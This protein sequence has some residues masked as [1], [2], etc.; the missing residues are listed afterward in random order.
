[1][2]TAIALDA[3]SARVAWPA[4]ATVGHEPELARVQCEA[5]YEA[6]PANSLQHASIIELPF[7]TALN[8]AGEILTRCLIG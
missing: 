8:E 5:G 6:L 7:T 3:N 2:P 1:M 4:F